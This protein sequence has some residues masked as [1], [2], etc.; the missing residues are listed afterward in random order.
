MNFNLKGKEGVI[1]VIVPVYKVEPY[2]H[3]CIG[4]I[5]KQTYK[6][7]QIILV[8]DGSPDN[9]GEICDEYAQKDARIQVIH[10]ENKGLS[11]ARNVG[12]EIAEGEYIGFVDSDDYIKETMYETMYCL[13]EERK[14][15][16][17]ICNLFD[18]KG[19]DKKIR[20]ANIGIKEYGKMDILKEII[21]DKNIQ[22]YA[23]NKL[24]KRELF[25]TIRYPQGKRYEDIGTTFYLLEKCNKVV[26][27]GEPQYYYLNREDS[28]V[29]NY[30]LQTVQDYTEIILQRYYHI[31]DNYPELKPYNEYYLTKTL[32]TAYNDLHNLQCI[33]KED[34]TIVQELYSEVK[35]IMNE[36]AVEIVSFLDEKQRKQIYNILQGN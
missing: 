29:N 17:C 22:S 21:L 8:D 10:Q 5:L 3:K 9:C 15:D 12:I 35:S 24:Y 27:T 6:N 4:S 18:V 36:N 30:N 20:N 26:M 31:K 19:N 34:I 2:I 28:I 25:K 11:A 7:L 14:A 16:V 33:R 32:V 1:S 13:I 23:W